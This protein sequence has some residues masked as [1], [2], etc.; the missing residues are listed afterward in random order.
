MNLSED[1][2]IEANR[3]F[4][5]LSSSGCVIVTVRISSYPHHG[6]ASE[7]R[8]ERDAGPGQ[9]SEAQCPPPLV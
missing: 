5:V 2:A 8:T 4:A 6:P 9:Q 7:A 3:S 1:A